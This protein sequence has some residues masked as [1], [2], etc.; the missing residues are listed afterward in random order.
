MKGIISIQSNL[1]FGHAGNS[2]AVFPIQRMGLEIWPIH[3]VQYSN[4]S[5]YG[6]GWTGH[7]YPANDIRELIQGLDNIEQLSNCEAIISGYQDSIEQC[8]AVR[9]SVVNIKHQ[10]PNALYVCDPSMEDIFIGKVATQDVSSPVI[11]ELMPIADVIVP[12]QYELERFTKCRI[13]TLE[14]A[15]VACKK[16]LELG[17]KVV[18][19]RNLTLVNNDMYTMMLITPKSA[20]LSQR[21]LL[22][23]TVRPGGINEL[24]TALFTA[25]LVKQMSPAVALRHTNNALYG[26]LELTCDHDSLELETITGQYEF[27]EPTYNF[28]LKKLKF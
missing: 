19:L 8:A 28:P 15:V 3:T 6:Q 20:Y 2:S 9:E 25:C 24:T 21:P 5:Q 13:E 1:V 11:E 12:N 7:G 23:F 14:Q 10:N 27:V 22:N 17:P 16:A 26:V 18:L 4:S